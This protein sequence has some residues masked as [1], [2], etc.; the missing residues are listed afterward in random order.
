MTNINIGCNYQ[1]SINYVGLIVPN[2]E[3]EAMHCF[4][5]GPCLSVEGIEIASR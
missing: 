2:S 5:A 1:C 4:R 3:T